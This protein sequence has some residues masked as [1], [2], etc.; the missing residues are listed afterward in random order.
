MS[1]C[2]FFFFILSDVIFPV[3]LQGKFEIDHSWG[4]KVSLK[5][6][7][8]SKGDWISIRSP[9]RAILPLSWYIRW[10]ISTLYFLI[11]RFFDPVKQI[12]FNC[13]SHNIVANLG[14][15]IGK[16]GWCQLR[17][18]EGGGGGGGEPLWME[19]WKLTGEEVGSKNNTKTYYISYPF[20][21]IFAE[22]K[23]R[24]Y[25]RQAS[26]RGQSERT[27]LRPERTLCNL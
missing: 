7:N 25:Y 11:W 16:Q 22:S 6:S 5:K 23:W 1:K 19:T 18:R 24:G 3:R 17:E 21:I 8:W 20:R 13:S 27:E 12:L 9:L 2:L 26:L 4:V 10:Y 14:G 15:T